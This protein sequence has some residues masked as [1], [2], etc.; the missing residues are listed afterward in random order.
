MKHLELS[1]GRLFIATE[2][3]IISVATL[4]GYGESKVYRLDQQSSCL[5]FAAAGE[6][7][8]GGFS[9][10]EIC[11]WN[12]SSGELMGTHILKKKAMSISHTNSDGRDVVIVADRAGEV[13]FVGAPLMKSSICVAGH[14]ASVITD[15]VAVAN[16]FIVTADRDEKIRISQFP[17]SAL[18]QSYCLGH[19]SVVASVCSF[20]LG[21]NTT[22]ANSQLMLA[23]TSWDHSVRLWEIETGHCCGV[24]HMSAEGGGPLADGHAETE[25][26]A[27][28]ETKVVIGV[29]VEGEGDEK[30]DEAAAADEEDNAEKD[31][32]EQSAGS[33]PFKVLAHALP[34]GRVLLFV[35]LR[36]QRTVNACIAT[37]TGD[38]VSPSASSFS[39]MYSWAAPDLPVDMAILPSEPAA[40]GF[41]SL[42]VLLPAPHYLTILSCSVEAEPTISLSTSSAH[43]SL[44]KECLSILATLVPGGAIFTQQASVAHNPGDGQLSTGH[45]LVKHSLDKPFNKLTGIKLDGMA[46]AGRGRK[47][48]IDSVGVDSV[49]AQQAV[50]DAFSQKPNV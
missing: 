7:I 17:Q 9:G 49:E 11:C 37:R 12:A 36:G 21:S 47:R 33:Y 27:E 19:T 2:N 41:V 26:E 16:R 32:D 10:K 46:N 38:G 20:R 45:I 44:M 48:P 13:W 18:I 15:M 35:L 29:E 43:H 25:A 23:S 34:D 30:G 50:S 28:G 31:Y 22:C 40:V 42:G 39:Q 4:S 14:T 6:Y 1:G 8:F 24:L 3:A 5:C